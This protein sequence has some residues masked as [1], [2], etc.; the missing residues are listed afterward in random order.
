MYI[1]HIYV[2]ENLCGCG[3][4]CVWV[5]VCV[6][7]YYIFMFVSCRRVCVN[8][9]RCSGV[10]SEAGAGSG[11]TFLALVGVIHHTHRHTHTHERTGAFDFG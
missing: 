5:C 3:C 1:L 11:V 10:R 9:Y 6:C 8:L 4:V 7:A 2:C